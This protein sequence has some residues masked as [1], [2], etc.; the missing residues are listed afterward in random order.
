MSAQTLD[1]MTVE[2]LRDLAQRAE[3]AAKVQEKAEAEKQRLA[4][5]AKKKA[6]I[7]FEHGEYALKK[8][9][10]LY[11][12]ALGGVDSAY[13][14]TTVAG[15]VATL[16]QRDGGADPG[17][18]VDFLVAYRQSLRDKKV[19]E[20]AYARQ[21][22]YYANAYSNQSYGFSYNHNPRY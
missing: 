17:E 10:K 14:R 6:E 22:Q 20:A 15:L 18:I 16:E 5:E 4:D 12:A 1:G 7:V 19:K 13:N 11:Y 3:A 9:G 8:D 21:Q 2:Q